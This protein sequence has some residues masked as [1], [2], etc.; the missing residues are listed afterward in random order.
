MEKM[1]RRAWMRI[2]AVMLA[3]VGVMV[4]LTST[5]D[6]KYSTDVYKIHVNPHTNRAVACLLVGLFST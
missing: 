6:S 4:S 1:K 2:M 5:K 3:I